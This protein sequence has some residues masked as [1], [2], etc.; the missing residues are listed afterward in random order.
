MMVGVGESEVE[1]HVVCHN[2]CT[3]HSCADCMLVCTVDKCK[4]QLSPTD[5]VVSKLFETIDSARGTVPIVDW[6]V[7][8]TT[9]EDGAFVRGGEESRHIVYMGCAFRPI[10]QFC[11]YF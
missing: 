11:N 10:I 3:V 4:Y 5:L 2:M 8:G 7:K 1:V 6:G 9:M